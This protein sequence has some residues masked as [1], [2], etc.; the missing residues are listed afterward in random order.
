[1]SLKINN[2]KKICYWVFWGIII[3]V[4]LIFFIR[5]AVWEGFYYAEKEGSERSV[6]ATAAPVR[7]ELDETEPTEEEIIEYNVPAGNPRYLTIPDIS[8]NNARILALST[9]ESGELEAPNNIFD[10]GWYVDSARP[11]EGGVILIDGHNGG[12][13]RYGIFKRLPELTIGSKIVIEVGQTGEKYTYIVQENTTVPLSEAN[14]YMSTAMKKI[15]NTE[16]LSIITCTGE[17]SDQQQTYLSRQFLRA[18]LEK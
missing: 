14:S 9:K 4:A 16:T 6:S 1:M 7:A 18:T 5:V 11:G 15:N 13:S 17:W 2:W 10:A 3:A 12:P 8:V